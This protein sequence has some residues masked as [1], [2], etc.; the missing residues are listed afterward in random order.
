MRVSITPNL[1]RIHHNST[2]VVTI[3][4]S[5][6]VLS[7]AKSFEISAIQQN[8]SLSTHLKKSVELSNSE[9]DWLCSS[10]LPGI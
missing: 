4:H 8:S 10:N 2:K 1:A 5:A 7:W 3:H 9:N 6:P